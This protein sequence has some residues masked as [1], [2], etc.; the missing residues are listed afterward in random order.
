[1]RLDKEVGTLNREIVGIKDKWKIALNIDSKKA[2]IEKLI[3]MRKKLRDNKEV[4]EIIKQATN[5]ENSKLLQKNPLNS[6]N[7]NIKTTNNIE[8]PNFILNSQSQINT[9]TKVID[10]VQSVPTNAPT[11]RN[12]FRDNRESLNQSE[13]KIV[14]IQPS[15]SEQIPTKSLSSDEN[16]SVNKL[17]QKIISKTENINAINDNKTQT[18]LDINPKEKDQ[19]AHLT[20]AWLKQKM[21]KK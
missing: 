21:K 16:I 8:Q 5:E 6:S 9:A 4:S 2:A 3:T 15:L 7:S 19:P 13:E 10:S 20:V 1:M 14:K 18:K 17:D 11:K 12:V